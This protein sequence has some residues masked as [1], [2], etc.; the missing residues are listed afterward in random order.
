[1][2]DPTPY[3]DLN[4]LLLKFLK[5]A[6][7]ILEGNFVGLYLTGSFALGDFDA[8]S[9]VD[10]LVVTGTDPSAAQESAIRAMHR[11]LYDLEMPWAQH[12]EGSYIRT[13]LLRQP[14]P[15]ATPLL[16]LD[17]TASELVWSAHCNN[18]VMRWTLREHGVTL[19]GQDPKT[20]LN[21]IDPNEL[22][23]EVAK[24]MERWG[25]ELLQKRALLENRWRQAF[26]VVSYCRMLYTLRTATIISKLEAVRWGMAA[27][28]ARWAGLI[29]RALADRP[30]PSLKSRQTANPDDARETAE[31]IRYALEIMD[32]M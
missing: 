13:D 22:R 2:H 7:R 16:Y 14:D 19:G 24:D 12:L 9:D 6:G 4:A 17:N 1:M 10:F 30:N 11:G 23:L 15:L 29:E 27:L 21:P 8:D 18:L 25:L 31:F 5:D 3:H 28:D 32:A 20:L 26:A